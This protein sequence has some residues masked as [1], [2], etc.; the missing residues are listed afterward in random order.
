M[1]LGKTEWK[2]LLEPLEVTCNQNEAKVSG[3]CTRNRQ[4]SSQTDWHRTNLIVT[5]LEHRHGSFY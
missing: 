2:G 5:E 4:G 3:I 1:G